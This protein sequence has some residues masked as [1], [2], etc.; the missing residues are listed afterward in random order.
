MASFDGATATDAD[1]EYRAIEQALLQSERGRW[2]LAEHSRR[3]RR[4][5]TSEIEV[6]LQRFKESLRE[7]PAVLTRIQSDL[8]E[9]DKMLA[10]ARKDLAIRSAETA[11]AE[12]P[13]ANLL[14]VAE[15]LHELIWSL[16]AREVDSATC[17]AIGQRTAAIFALTA[18][19][20]QE[21]QRA[22]RFGSALDAIAGKVAEVLRSVGYEACSDEG[23]AQPAGWEAMPH[24]AR[25]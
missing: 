13:T 2:F 4:T 12:S 6:A 11:P 25:P 5:E 1:T 23:A 15:E 21:S 8:V 16:Q 24:M 18:R 3:S 9:I 17:E 19:Q 20:A 10:D 14:K 7:P 22:M